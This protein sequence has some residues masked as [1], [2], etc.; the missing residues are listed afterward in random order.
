MPEIQVPEIVQKL[1]ER[2]SLKGH[3]SISTL[4]PEIV[5][6]VLVEDLAASADDEWRH[7]GFGY[8]VS[9]VAAQ[10]S[11][12]GLFNPVGSGKLAEITGFLV[13]MPSISAVLFLQKNAL[14]SAH[15]ACVERDFRAGSSSY[16]SCRFSYQNG[17]ATGDQLN[18]SAFFGG[19][20]ARWHPWSWIL[21]EG[22]G[23]MWGPDTAN[24]TMAITC[25]FRER[26]KR[27]DDTRV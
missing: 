19:S 8:Q 6:V 24:L 14:L 25:M 12:I 13:R 21:S 10:F 17:A 22:T 5:P 16:A 20:D 15:T 2:F 9:A 4:A 18:C 11:Q 26:P 1:R 3:A 27:D 23:V 7:Y